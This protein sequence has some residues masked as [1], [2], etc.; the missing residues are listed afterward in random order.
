MSMLQAAFRT[1]AGGVS[2]GTGGG[3]P[4]TIQFQGSPAV[5]AAAKG[6]N[7]SDATADEWEILDDDV[8]HWGHLFSEMIEGSIDS[9]DFVNPD[10]IKNF[11]EDEFVGAKK[12]K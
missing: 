11:F 12:K 7:T 5:T 1:A 9:S 3:G 10:E 4:K 2:T 6:S 8:D